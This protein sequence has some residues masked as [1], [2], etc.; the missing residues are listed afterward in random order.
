MSVVAPPEPP[1]PDELEALIRE[2]RARQRR[3]R[4]TVGVLVAVAAAAGLSL[5]SIFSGTAPAPRS[6]A[7]S[8]RAAQTSE[9]CRGVRVAGRRIYYG[10]RVVY[11]AYSAPHYRPVGRGPGHEVQCSGSTVWVVFD[12]GGLA[13]QGNYV[14]VRSA[15][16]GRSW[17]TVFAE[18]YFGV[19][20]PHLLVTGYLGPWTLDG[21]R[22][23]YFVGECVACGYGTVSLWVT[24]DL[25]RTFH[26]YAVP[27]PEG[28]R[29]ASVRVGRQTVAISAHSVRVS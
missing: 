23:A 26:R 28:S 27:W 24:T 19:K 4:L 17:R 1:R 14:G 8:S 13:S 9:P 6:P 18:G 20:A 11:T 29:S 21:P 15:D 25:G 12:N 22:S 5:Q 16:H 2:A 3:R 7:D 10:G